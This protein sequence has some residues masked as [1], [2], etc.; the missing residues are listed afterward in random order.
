MAWDFNNLTIRVVNNTGSDIS[1][2]KV[3]AVLGFDTTTFLPRIVLADA[4][5]ASTHAEFFRTKDAIANGDTGYILKGG[6]SA[7]NLD[8]SSVSAA[9]DP[10][11]LS[12]TAG[13][14]TAT[15]P[16]AVDAVV[17]PLGWCK[18]K[19]ATI[20]QI[21]W[22]I[23]P[24]QKVGSNQLQ[25][26]AG[27]ATS[28]LVSAAGA[29]L[30]VTATLHAGRTITMDQA[31][32]TT[33]TLPAPT[34]TG[35]KYR[36]VCTVASNANII[37][38]DVTGT[39]MYGGVLINDTGDTSAATADFFP[40]AATSNRITLTTAGGGGATGDW[41]E[42]QDTATGF[43]SVRGVFKGALDPVTPFSHF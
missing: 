23:G 40:T 18:V 36:F 14:F 42:V 27:G 35:N 8:T 10:V 33:F 7:A 11:Y 1:A 38:A 24:P 3:V 25:S 16:T 15:A 20:G 34:G 32:G 31:G 30:T 2:D 41:I 6:L 9:G 13:A 29:N 5:T 17:V 19:S 4:D 22:H 37:N 39:S 28:G 26:G 12:A 43:W 21:H